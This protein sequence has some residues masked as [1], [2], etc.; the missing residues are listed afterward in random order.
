MV[1][2]SL[3]FAAPA[4]AAGLA[5]SGCTATMATPYEFSNNE[6]DGKKIAFPVDV[7]CELNRTIDLWQWALED[8]TGWF[9]HNDAIGPRRNWND[10]T[11]TAATGKNHRFLLL[12]YLDQIDPSEW[13]SREEV[14]H[15]AQF[16]VW[17]SGTGWT[18]FTPV[19]QSPN[20]SFD[21]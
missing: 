13:E 21:R 11:F 4:N 12:R 2:L 16:R 1:A 3:A 14:F 19:A 8:D 10:Y 5:R 20:A 6:V 7:T 9:D 17:R 15:E 18:G